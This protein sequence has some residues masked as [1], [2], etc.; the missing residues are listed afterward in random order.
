MDSR[1][2]VHYVI[3]KFSRFYRLPIYLSNGAPPRALR[4]REL[5]YKVKMYQNQGHVLYSPEQGNDSTSSGFGFGGG[6]RGLVVYLLYHRNIATYI[7]IM[8]SCLIKVN[9]RNLLTDKLAKMEPFACII[10]QNN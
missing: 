10:S 9:L 1:S 4:P 6:A 2:G 7:T 5:R 3:T 8:R